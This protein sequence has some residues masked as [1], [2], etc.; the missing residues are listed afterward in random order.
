[1]RKIIQISTTVAP[2]SESSTTVVMSALCD[3]G[4][5]WLWV[6]TLGGWQRMPDIPQ[7]EQPEPVPAPDLKP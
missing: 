2:T 5:L 6:G 7:D 3:D 4:S 1:M